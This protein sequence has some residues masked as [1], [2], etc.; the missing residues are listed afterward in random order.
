MTN[1]SETFGRLVRD[2]DQIEL[3]VANRRLHL[4]VDEAELARRRAEWRPPEPAYTRGYGRLF[5][6]RVT[7]APWGC[8]FDFLCGAT[9]VRTPKQPKF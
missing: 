1:Q 8:D 2:G 3:D 7:Q 5:L 4:H 6:E 9:P